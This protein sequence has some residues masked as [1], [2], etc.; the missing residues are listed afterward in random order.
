M[1]DRL[2]RGMNRYF[3]HGQHLHGSRGVSA[4]L[5]GVGVVVELR[6]LAPGDDARERRLALPRRAAQ[7]AP[8][9]RVLAAKPADLRVAGRIPTST[10]PKSVTVSLIFRCMT[11]CG[12]VCV[13]SPKGA[14][15]HSQRCA[16]PGR[17]QDAPWPQP[18]RGGSRRKWLYG[19]GLPA[20]PAGLAEAPAVRRDG[21]SG[22]RHWLWTAA[23]TGL[24]AETTPQSILSHY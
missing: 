24:N 22:S 4:A 5:P 1:L 9:P 11:G 14:A 13:L 7:P 17:D 15:V 2:M 10:P 8:I 12:V 20:A 23:P 18:R 19:W 3:D 6:A 16:A 21:P